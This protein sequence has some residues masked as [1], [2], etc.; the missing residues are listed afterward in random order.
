MARVALN[1]R[2]LGILWRPPYRVD[3]TDALRPGGN[4]FEVLVT[5]LWVNRMI[6]DEYLPEDS[7][8]NPD[9]TLAE[10]PDWLLEGQPGPTGRYTF[11]TWR[12]WSRNDPLQPSGL[13]GPVSL[14]SGPDRLGNAPE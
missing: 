5:N 12:M 2:D 7:A 1:G 9:G 10:W 3:V 4:T 8:R 6:G 13:L 14:S 11:T